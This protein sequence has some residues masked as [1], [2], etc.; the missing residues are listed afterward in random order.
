M[1]F[2][3]EC[4]CAKE[5]HEKHGINPFL[6]SSYRHF[7]APVRSG[8]PQPQ[9]PNNRLFQC[10]TQPYCQVNGP[11]GYIDISLGNS[12][13]IIIERSGRALWNDFLSTLG[14]HGH[15]RGDF[16]TSVAMARSFRR[17]A[18]WI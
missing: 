2:F 1:A 10:D 11:T 17:A 18:I 13:K 14:E 3:I 15:K 16:G 6:H 9:P 12:T 7:S 4:F 5:S 8:N